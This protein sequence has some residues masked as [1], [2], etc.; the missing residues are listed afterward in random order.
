MSFQSMERN[1]C[2]RTQNAWVDASLASVWHYTTQLLA[3]RCQPKLLVIVIGV[4]QIRL[5]VTEHFFV[6]LRENLGEKERDLICVI[7]LPSWRELSADQ[8][9]DDTPSNVETIL[10]TKKTFNDFLLFFCILAFRWEREWERERLG[11]KQ[12][13]PS[14]R[15]R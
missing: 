12:L 14:L 10:G 7:N 4:L 15:A 6:F 13:P 11:W 8:L 1:E 5:Q 2:R 9:H 3:L